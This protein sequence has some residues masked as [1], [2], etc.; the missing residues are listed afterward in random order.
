MEEEFYISEQD[1]TFSMKIVRF[2]FQRMSWIAPNYSAKLFWQLFTQPRKRPLN[3]HHQNF[4]QKAQSKIYISHQFKAPYTVHRF[5]SGSKKVLLCHGWEGRTVDFRNI[6]EGLIQDKE[7]EVISIDF[8][9]HGTSAQNEAHLPIFVDVISHF[10]QKQPDV[11]V[12]LGH[13]LGAASLAV[14]VGEIGFDF[15][16]KK[17]ILMGLHPEPSQFFFQYK[18]ITRI[19]EK[20]FKKCVK[21]AEQKA[22]RTLLDIDFHHYVDVYNQ[23][24]MLF[25][26]DTEDKIIHLRRVVDFAKK[27]ENA[28]VYHSKGGGHLKHFKNQDVLEVIF[29]YINED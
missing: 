1:I 25:V 2:Y 7:I 16:N 12:L 26:H 13:S 29:H 28:K 11:S 4:L 20:V 18:K 6:I 9:G 8:P 19:N 21:L 27:L 14:A 22:N 3:L 23:N 15:Q 17:M 5:G 24:K 10:I